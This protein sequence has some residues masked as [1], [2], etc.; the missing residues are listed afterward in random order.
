MIEIQTLNEN[1]CNHEQTRA[2]LKAANANFSILR[3]AVQKLIA[4]VEEI[5]RTCPRPT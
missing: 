1:A 5:K 2:A 4:D 3:A